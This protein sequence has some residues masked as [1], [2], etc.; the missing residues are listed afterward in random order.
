MIPV[1]PSIRVSALYASAREIVVHDSCD[2]FQI[3]AV[4]EK[5]HT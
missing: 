1:R 5:T 3:E 2:R 4:D